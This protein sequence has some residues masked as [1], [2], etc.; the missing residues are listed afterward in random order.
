MRKIV[1]TKELKIILLKAL[2]KGILD[3]DEL[4]K[5][6]DNAPART[7]SKEEIKEYLKELED[8]Y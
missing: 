6:Q 7:L 4:I 8:T 3:L 1:L 5:L 2:K